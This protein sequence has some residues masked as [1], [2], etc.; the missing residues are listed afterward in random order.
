M[1]AIKTFVS[2]LTGRTI[3]E[4]MSGHYSVRVIGRD[5][6]GP[7]MWWALSVNTM[8]GDK[9]DIGHDTDL[10]NAIARAKRYINMNHL[11]AVIVVESKPIV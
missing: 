7:N 11:N 8:A 2:K 6:F 3:E 10:D 5:D 9:L 4:F 1:A